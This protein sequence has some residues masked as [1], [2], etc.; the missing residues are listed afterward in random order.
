[1]ATE[2]AKAYVQII[3]SAKGISSGIE[4]ALDGEMKTSSQ[5]AA[6]TFSTGF[7]KAAGTAIAAEAAVVGAAVGTAF[8]SLIKD[9][10]SSYAETEQLV[11]GIQTLFGLGGQTL[12]EYAKEQKKAVGDVLQEWLSLTDGE[13]IALDNSKEAYKTAGLSANEYMETVTGFSA[14]L[15]KSLAGDTESAAIKADMAITDMSDNA[16]KMGSSMESIQNAYQ[17]FAKQNYT[18]LDNLK[19]GY[20]GTKE[21]M[22]KLLSDATELSGIEYDISSFADIVDAIH[23]IQEEMGIA[24]TTQKEAADTISGSLGMTRAAWDNLVAGLA[25]KS[26]NIDDLISNLVDSCIVSLDNLAPVI[27]NALL[28]ATEFCE[29]IIPIISEQFPIIV[30][31]VLPDIMDAAILLIESL[32]SSI[33]ENLPSLTETGMQVI[34][35][36]VRYLI[37][38]LPLLL[39]SGLAIIATIADGLTEALPELTT[40]VIEILLQMT[41]T[42]I[43]NLPILVMSCMNLILALVE[44]LNEYLPMLLDYLPELM[45]SLVQAIVQLAPQLGIAALE[46]I[47]ALVNGIL[48]CIPELINV[49]PE[50]V[51][52]LTTSLMEVDWSSYGSNIMEKFNDGI[53]GQ[54]D[55][56]AKSASDIFE[57]FKTHLINRISEMEYIG[58]NFLVGLW[59]GI[60]GEGSW[61]NT[62]VKD[63][64][65][66]MLTTVKNALGVHSPSVKME[67]VGQMVDEG[68]G[69]G[70]KRNTDKVIDEALGMSQ[71][72]L[73][74]VNGITNPKTFFANYDVNSNLNFSNMQNSQIDALFQILRVLS[75]YLPMLTSRDIRLDTGAVVGQ[76]APEIDRQLGRLA[77][78]AGR[79]V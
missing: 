57:A 45:T 12:Q 38:S 22:E 79:G 43:Q 51:A 26:A 77:T 27:E 3:P 16:N 9:S 34:L 47:L 14:S 52:A 15:I 64:C 68:L 71:S 11:G 7:L 70:I 50:I 73:D 42:L 18:M 65:N 8:T 60:S 66:S 61:L 30:E 2:I 35:E 58:K 33:L 49:V 67:W 20:G 76:L 39:S 75:E 56:L 25:D 1:M 72:V 17:G 59:D 78:L 21:E 55:L 41:D 10:V 36:L 28:G 31:E 37:D 44:G 54:V 29:K 53:V 13:R 40:S 74:T 46:L 32:S 23:V 48:M 24:G 69:G 19:L 4:T 6:S 62:K 5:K 63:L